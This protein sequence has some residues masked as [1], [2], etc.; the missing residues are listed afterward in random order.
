MMND[1]DNFRTKAP[2]SSPDSQRV[3]NVTFNVLL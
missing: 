2:A 1:D 3:L